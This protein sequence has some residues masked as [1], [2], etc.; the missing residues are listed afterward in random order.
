MSTITFIAE[1]A[2]Y[3]TAQET[4]RWY[5]GIGVY[6]FMLAMAIFLLLAA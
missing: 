6:F 5:D 3:A 1:D 2:D 4:D